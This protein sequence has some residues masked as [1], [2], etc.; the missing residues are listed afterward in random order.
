MTPEE[1]S[2]LSLAEQHEWFRRA[3][4]RRALLRGGMATAG[5]AIA[6][7]ALLGGTASAATVSRS[8][9]ML[10][11]KADMP[12][13]ALVPAF[14]RHIMFGADP[15]TQMAVAWQ[16][17]AP[18]SRPFLRVGESPFDLGH[19]IEAEI[20]TVTTPRSDTSPVDSVAPSAA[21]T[22]EQYYVHASVRGL[23]PGRTYYYS[24][25]HQ[26]QDP[27]RLVASGTFTTARRGREPFTFTAFGDQ[28]VSYDAVATSTLVRAQNPAFHLHA[29]D[30]SSA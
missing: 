29:G 9:P 24:V 20:R 27:S 6:A 7:P 17:A 3:T 18:V 11:T 22:I 16:V 1:A 28:G 14:G 15:A 30:V 21:A 26:G 8:T 23:R 12:D 4:S 13:G 2:R 5:A 19:Q 25:G 10:L